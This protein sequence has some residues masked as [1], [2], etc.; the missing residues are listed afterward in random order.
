MLTLFVVG[1]ESRRPE[2]SEIERE[3][4]QPLLLLEGRG[5]EGKESIRRGEGDAGRD[6]SIVAFNVIISVVMVD[7]MYCDERR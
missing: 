5:E 4:L 6:G 7:Q 1:G 3:T 2:R